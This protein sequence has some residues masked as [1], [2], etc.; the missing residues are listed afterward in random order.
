MPDP[1]RPDCDGVQVREPVQVEAEIPAALD[2][3]KPKA[4]RVGLAGKPDLPPEAV[5]SQSNQRSR[6]QDRRDVEAGPP[7]PAIWPGHRDS[8]TGT[9]RRESGEGD[10]GQQLP[11]HAVSLG[12]S[13]RPDV[14]P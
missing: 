2:P 5:T 11:F 8:D 13:G 7:F 6:R 3:G 4:R 12:Q 10:K 1:V 9:G 14:R